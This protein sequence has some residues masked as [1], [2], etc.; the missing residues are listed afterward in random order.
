MKKWPKCLWFPFCYTAFSQLAPLASAD[1]RNIPGLQIGLHNMQ[2][3]PESGQ[4]Q[5]YSPFLGYPSRTVVKKN[6]PTR[7]NFKMCISFTLLGKTSGQSWWQGNLEKRHLCMVKYLYPT[8]MFTKGWPQQIR[9]IKIKWIG[10]LALQI[11]S[12]TLTASFLS[13]SGPHPMG[14][15]TNY[16]WWQRWRSHLSS[17][18]QTSTHQGHT[19][20]HSASSREQQWVSDTELLPGIISQLPGGRLITIRLPPSWKGQHFVQTETGPLD[21]FLPFLYAILLPKLPPMD[22]ED[23]LSTII[24]VV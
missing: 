12:P 11:P 20:V 18:I 17:A 1:H 6:S 23:T 19:M 4:L 22:L 2:G 15:W 8:W 24:F 7:Q 14:S 3:S 16:V 9:I 5:Q 21:I 10:W 13:H